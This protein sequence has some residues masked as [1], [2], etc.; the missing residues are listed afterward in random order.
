[1]S[2][3]QDIRNILNRIDG[4]NA[5]VQEK[6]DNS[7]IDIR[8]LLVD[9]SS[10]KDRIAELAIS[11]DAKTSAFTALAQ[12]EEDIA[13]EIKGQFPES[14]NEGASMIPYFKSEKEFDGEKSTV[15]EFPMA[16][17]K[18][19][20]LDTPYLSNAS[21][22]QFLTLLGY[23]ADFEEMSAVPIDEFIGVSTQWLKKNI[24]KPS[25]EIPTTVD[26]SGGGATMIGGGKPEGWDNRQVQHHN[27]LA[28]K[29]KSKY[30]EVTH[31]GFN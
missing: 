12:V 24:G 20:E 5:P 1:M 31:L 27:E 7:D 25:Q 19:K 16:W 3:Y 30:P 15:Y 17:A 8:K 26:R 21:M 13:Q 11:D 22:R 10:M 14:V 2:N 18:D 9:I 29:I 4:V 28:R 6:S 23:P